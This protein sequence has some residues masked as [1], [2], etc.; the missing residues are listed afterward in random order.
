MGTFVNSHLIYPC[1][2][3]RKNHCI[4]PTSASHALSLVQQRQKLHW[5]WVFHIPPTPLSLSLSSHYF[6]WLY[7]ILNRISSHHLHLLLLCKSNPTV[8][9]QHP[10]A[11]PL[12]SYPCLS[13]V[14]IVPYFLH[15]FL[16]S[17]LSSVF[18]PV[19]FFMA[20]IL[21]NNNGNNTNEIRREEIQAAIAKAVE[22]RAIHASLVRGS[23]PSNFRYP[24]PSPVPHHH[25]P[26]FSAHDYP[27]FTPV[28]SLFFPTTFF[29]SFCNFFFCVIFLEFCLWVLNVD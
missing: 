23:S 28:S 21:Q 25:T 20:Q 24:S 16:H 8:Q 12:C 4:P 22:L 10:V 27:V 19:F 6:L 5:I 26:Q 1:L 9:F 29:N 2:P 7:T 11:H 18:S 17:V 3:C 14:Q 13:N 15:I